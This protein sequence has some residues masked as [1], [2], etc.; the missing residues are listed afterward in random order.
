MNPAPWY[1]RWIPTEEK[2]RQSRWLAWLAPWLGRPSLWIWSRHGVALGVALGVFFGMLVPI[3]QIPA[4][5]IAAVVL[6]ANLPAAAASTFVSNPITFAPVYYL[7]YQLGNV[8][9]GNEP[10]ERAPAQAN[11]DKLQKQLTEEK[12]LGFWQRLKL[13]GKPLMV[14]LSIMATAFGLFSY[15]LISLIWFA[16]RWWREYKAGKDRA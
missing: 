13:M 14:G 16:S 11:A 10:E 8:V 9:L 5:A 1:Q 7:A 4:S 12:Q 15:V 3:A 2:L 6:R